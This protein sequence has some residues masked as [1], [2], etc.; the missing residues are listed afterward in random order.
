[1]SCLA[2]SAGTLAMPNWRATTRQT[3]FDFLDTY[4][5]ANPTVLRQVHKTRPGSFRE[6]PC[7]FIG[8][9]GLTFLHAGQVR[10]TG[11]AAELVF[12][13]GLADNTEAKDKLDAVV[14]AITEALTDDPHVLGANTVCEP[15]S[16]SDD[17]IEQ[18]GVVY[19]AVTLTVGRITI[20][21]GRT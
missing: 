16:I 4:K 3:L 11:G 12:V 1:M 5:T 17:A 8:E 10:Q 15:M 20:V 18:G 14:D 21:E 2:R 9:V 7:A 19:T 6:L 13:A